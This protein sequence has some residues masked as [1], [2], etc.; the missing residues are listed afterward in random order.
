MLF[1][2]K[3]ALYLGGMII[4]T[5]G[6]R[7][8][9][10]AGLGADA[11]DALC[12]GLS[13]SAGLTPGTWVAATAFLMMCTAAVLSGRKP[14]AGGLVSSFIF[15]V[16]FDLW[17][18]FFQ[19]FYEPDSMGIRIL[20]YGA[21]ILLG[22]L[23]TAIYFKSGFAKSALDDFIFAIKDRLHLSIRVTKTSVEIGLCTLA[24]LFGGPIGI[25]TILTAVLYGPLLQGFMNR[26]DNMCTICVRSGLHG[27]VKKI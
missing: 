22:P 10:E 8:F 11:L 3:G 6:Q 4:L 15:G 27:F 26:L 12:V 16:F 17:A 5:L 2:R 25:A 18:R 24:F 23:G 13:E 1:L 9:V 19:H 7:L 20:M 21:G 14:L